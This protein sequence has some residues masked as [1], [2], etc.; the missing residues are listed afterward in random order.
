MKHKDWV[1]LFKIFLEMN[2]ALIPYLEG[3]QGPRGA[4][5]GTDE[6][7]RAKNFIIYA[8]GWSSNQGKSDFNYWETLHHEWHK[9]VADVNSRA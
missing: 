5:Y 2:D 8:F 7:T 3:L 1:A 4:Y 6:S 9:V